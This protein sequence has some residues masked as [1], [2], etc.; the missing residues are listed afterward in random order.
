MSWMTIITTVFDFG[1]NERLVRQLNRLND[2]TKETIIQ[3][4]FAKL[5][6]SALAAVVFIVSFGLHYDKTGLA[7]LFLTTIVSAFGRSICDFAESAMIALDQITAVATFAAIQSTLICL[8]GVVAATVIRPTASII[9]FCQGLA[10]SLLALW[11]FK[12]LK[13]NVANLPSKPLQF[14]SVSAIIQ[15]SSPFGIMSL[16]A[17]FSSSAPIILMAEFENLAVG[18]GSLQGAQRIWLAIIGLGAGPFTWL[19][20]QFSRQLSVR[21]NQSKKLAEALLLLYNLASLV[22]TF[23]ILSYGEKLIKLLYADKMTRAFDILVWLALSLPFALTAYVPGAW[24][25]AAYGERAKMCVVVG[26]AATQFALIAISASFLSIDQ[27]AAIISGSWIFQSI[28][29][30]WIARK[31]YGLES[32]KIQAIIMP[33]AISLML[34]SKSLTSYLPW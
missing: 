22:I 17:T 1:M 11:R 5:L 27:V 23:A 8:S 13:C 16:A 34:A 6:F 28:L 33:A 3:T 19:F 10:L 9:L 21:S 4:L 15:E 26:I 32:H 24:L 7:I 2:N 29:I 31:W 30:Y 18:M 12:A 25:P 20:A 14:R